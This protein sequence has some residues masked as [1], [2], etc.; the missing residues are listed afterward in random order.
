MK[1][2]VDYDALV[3]DFDGVIA[4]T[5][6]LHWRAW[7]ELLSEAGFEFS[8]ADY[9]RLGRGVH[10]KD[11]VK[12]LQAFVPGIDLEKVSEDWRARRRERVREWCILEP[13]ISKQTIELIRGLRVKKLG[14]VTSSDRS[15]IEPI[16][17]L[18]GI[19]ES[20]HALVFGDDVLRHKPLPDPY[21]RISEL[22]D[23]QNGVAFEDSDSGIQSARSAGFFTVRI[24]DP[25]DL[26]SAVAK[27]C[28]ECG[29]SRL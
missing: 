12:S 1:E 4:D 8:W 15:E 16:L 5:E 19:Y 27:V 10:D 9:C 28:Q 14:L 2:D 23:I 13:P 20:F 26:S 22:L 7:K 11:M 21:L 18:A 3:F 29:M 17:R 24:A 25:H 6:T